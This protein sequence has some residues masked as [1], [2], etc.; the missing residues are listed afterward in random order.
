MMSG[1]IIYSDVTFT[2]HQNQDTGAESEVSNGVAEREEDVTYSEVRRPGGR[3]SEQEDPGKGRDPG[4]SDPTPPMGSKA[5]IPD[6]GSGRV[7]VATLVCLCVLLLGLAITLG[8][9]YA[10]NMTSLQ[11]EGARFAQ[12]KDNLTGK[13][14]DLQDSYKR[15][16]N[17]TLIITVQEELF[18]S[19]L[20]DCEANLTRVKDLLATIQGNPKECN[21]DTKPCSPGWEFYNGS[22]YYFSI[23]ILTWEQSQYACIRDGGHLVII[24]SQQEQIRSKRECGSGWTIQLLMTESSSGT[25]TLKHFQPFQNQMTGTQVK[26]VPEWVKAVPVESNVGLTLHVTNHVGESVRVVQSVRDAQPLHSAAKW[27]VLN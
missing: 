7:P 5:T 3:A 14:H 24:E 25:Q 27:N 13:L 4:N 9:L 6:G 16:Q 22:C 26:T 1:E 23:G 2:R 18:S 8:V 10:S 17:K 11:A 20:R 12:M 15:L 21:A 19:G